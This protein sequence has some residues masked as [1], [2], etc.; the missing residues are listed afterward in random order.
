MYHPESGARWIAGHPLGDRIANIGQRLTGE[1]ADRDPEAASTWLG[2]LQPGKVRDEAATGLAKAV[3]PFDPKAAF[4]WALE[5]ADGNLRTGA[6]DH[7]FGIWL[8]SDPE[9][10]L[11]ALDDSKLNGEE[12]QRLRDLE[13]TNE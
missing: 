1:W 12:K 8:W 11:L 7:A 9:A 3:A 4:A 10:A 13:K 5:I 2:T 6:L